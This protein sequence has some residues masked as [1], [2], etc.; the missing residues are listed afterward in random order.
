MDNL[1]KDNKCKTKVIRGTVT[2]EVIASDTS[3]LSISIDG[4]IGDDAV[5]SVCQRVVSN[6][7]VLLDSIHTYYGYIE[8]GD[9]TDVFFYCTNN[10]ANAG[11]VTLNYMIVTS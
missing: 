10:S 1:I 4:Y 2:G 6:G 5:I 8:Q 11:T 7:D 3:Y 9:R